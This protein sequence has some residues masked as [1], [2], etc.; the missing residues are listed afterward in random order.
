MSP[1]RLRRVFRPIMERISFPAV[2]LCFLFRFTSPLDLAY[3]SCQRTRGFVFLYGALSQRA[4]TIDATVLFFSRRE[5][6]FL[7]CW[8][9][10]SR[11]HG[12]IKP[13]VCRSRVLYCIAIQW[14]DFFRLFSFSRLYTRVRQR[15]P[16]ACSQ[17]QTFR[18]LFSSFL[19]YIYARVY[20]NVSALYWIIWSR[21]LSFTCFSAR[22][23]VSSYTYSCAQC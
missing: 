12:Y 20:D 6:A 14:T 13:A 22:K 7:N 1:P 5:F 16:I 4:R 2:R 23:F 8:E 10:F 11:A 9:Y 17:K 3:A 18:P 15:L 19:F 21:R